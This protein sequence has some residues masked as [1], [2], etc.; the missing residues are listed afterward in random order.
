[1]AKKKFYGVHTGLTPGVYETWDE[2]K[3]QIDGFPGAKYK[4]FSTKEEAQAFTQQ[5]DY[6]IGK[7]KAAAPA[8][9]APA[10]NVTKVSSESV[11]VEA[12]TLNKPFAFVDGSFNPETSV[13]GYGGF[14]NVDGRNYPVEG[15]GRNQEM[16]SMRNVAGEIS[17]AIAAVKKAESL[18]VS[19]LVMLY[20]YRGIEEW[21]TGGW[22]ANK[23]STKA[24]K[25]FMNA[26]ERTVNVTFEHVDAH[27]GID[28]NEKA[29]VMAKHAV[30]V[31]LTPKQSALYNEA[32][33]QSRR[34]VMTLPWEEEETSVD[35]D[36]EYN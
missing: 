19:D 13:Y 5:G 6:D 10:A 18:G 2:C 28:G 14:V 15:S 16:A 24:Y 1:M 22:K 21:A 7:T 26:P 20:D 32:I 11:S 29:D 33:N 3:A 34:D 31:A 36:C 23:Q 12:K 9:T 4:G 27:T 35:F 25:E 8:Q 30:G 17:G